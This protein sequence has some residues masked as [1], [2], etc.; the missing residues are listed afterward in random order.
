M[1]ILHQDASG[2]LIVSHILETPR[3]AEIVHHAVEVV[4]HDAVLDEATGAIITEAYDETI[5]EAWD[6][7]VT[8]AETDA[9][10]AS[11]MV[12]AHVPDGARHVVVD[13]ASLPDGVPPERWSVDWQTGAVTAQPPPPVEVE[14]AYA[15]AVQVHIDAT[16]RSRGYS[17]GVALASYAT[18][19]VPTWATEA[20]AFVAWRDSVWVQCYQTLAAVQQ[21]QQTAP[22]I[23][24]LIAALPQ[25]S[26][27]Q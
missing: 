19:T 8:P 15:A 18:S 3:P 20:Q 12:A 22:T 14:A 13:P 17:D 23:G 26:W 1:I 24:A 16:A 25:I 4:R 2:R 10:F 21:G 6:E 11:R 5:A 27:P 9:E 7:T